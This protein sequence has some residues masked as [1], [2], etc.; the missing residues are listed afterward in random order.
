[1]SD[2]DDVGLVGMSV[3]ARV[4]P[5]A[6]LSFLLV[7]SCLLGTAACASTAPRSGPA[8]GDGGDDRFAIRPMPEGWFVESAEVATGAMFAAYDEGPVANLLY[9]PGGR[10]EGD[11]PALLLGKSET[12]DWMPL[13]D[14]TAQPVA[15]LG[16]APDGGALKHFGDFTVVHWAQ[17]VDSSSY[18]VARGLSDSEVVTVARAASA[19]PIGEPTAEPTLSVPSDRLPAGWKL[20]AS[21]RRLPRQRAYAPQRI[22]I[23]NGD[24]TARV[25][26]LAYRLDDEAATIDGLIAAL[27]SASIYSVSAPR[28]IGSTHVLAIAR[29]HVSVVETL[30][31]SMESVTAE[32]WTAFQRTALQVP[33]TALCRDSLRET[34]TI[35]VKND[36]VRVVIAVPKPGARPEA[37][38]IARVVTGREPET[39]T[40]HTPANDGAT[41]VT[42]TVATDS[43]SGTDHW[44]AMGGTVP[45]GTTR[46]VIESPGERSVDAGIVD[47]VGDSA[48]RYYGAYIDR[49]APRFFSPTVIAYGPDGELARFTS[50]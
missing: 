5:R 32:Q 33:A 13:G 48:R 38:C 28:R 4:R 23:V 39:T 2:N 9:A 36:T 45:V 16:S 20:V 15:G 19:E 41:G 26:V 30:A 22:V 37:G 27:Q 7:V 24:G 11:G 6:A 25:D 1:M 14:P 10:F 46:V 29:G 18:V 21:A 12:D 47:L 50:G 49:L 3:G 17:F 40:G 34:A 8:K 31:R 42:F 43:S 35:A 44:T